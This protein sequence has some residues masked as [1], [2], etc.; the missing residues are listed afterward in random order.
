MIDYECFNLI[1]SAQN[2]PFTKIAGNPW[3]IGAHTLSLSLYICISIW[4]AMAHYHYPPN[5]IA[6]VNFIHLK[7]QVQTAVTHFSYWQRIT[8]YNIHNPR[9]FLTGFF[10]HLSVGSYFWCS[11]STQVHQNLTF[12]THPLHPQ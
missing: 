10:V 8:W 12:N 4:Y 6:N 2:S 1:G 9:H 11:I 7:A 3:T 5:L